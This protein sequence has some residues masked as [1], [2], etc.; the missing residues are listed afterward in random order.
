MKKLLSGPLKRNPIVK[1]PFQQR[2]EILLWVSLVVFTLASSVFAAP[3]FTLGVF[4]GG[5]ISIVNFFWLG[6]DLRAVFRSLNQAAQARLLF[7]YYIRFGVTAVVLYFIVKSDIVD[8]FGLLI[9]LSL[10]V[11]NIVAS[12]IMELTK[13]NSVEEVR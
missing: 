13:K 10:V 9:G 12:A 7:K 5:C 1:D 6:R 11:I 4:L 3:K 2:L 8:I